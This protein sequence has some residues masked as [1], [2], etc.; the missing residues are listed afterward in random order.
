MTDLKAAAIRGLRTALFTFLAT[1][2]PSLLG[3]FGQIMEWAESGGTSGDI[4]LSTLGFAVV[5]ASVAALSGLVSFL[6]NWAENSKGFAIFG[7]KADDK[8]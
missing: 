8:S 5:S 3:F 6:W 1:F 4:S 7:A 2:L